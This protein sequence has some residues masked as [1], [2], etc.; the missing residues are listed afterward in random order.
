MTR[1]A[2]I[3]RVAAMTSRSCQVCSLLGPLSRGIFQSDKPKR[4][5]FS[6]C[7]E[8]EF[9]EFDQMESAQGKQEK[10]NSFNVTGCTSWHFAYEWR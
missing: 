2:W 3:L 5:R 4:L 9:L 1:G 7:P 8:Q 10:F 6:I